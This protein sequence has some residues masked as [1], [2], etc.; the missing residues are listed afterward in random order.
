MI[1]LILLPVLVP[2][3][4]FILLL[5]FRR[6]VVFNQTVAIVS[7]LIQL[8]ISLLLLNR[9]LV[10][11]IQVTQLGSWP[12]PYGITIV[13]DLFSAIMVALSGIIATVIGI[14][15]VSGLSKDYHKGSFYPLMAVL[16]MGVNGAFL[17]GDIFNLYVWFEVMILASFVLLTMG[18]TRKQ[19]YGGMKYMTI[20][21]VSSMIFL[22]GIGVLYG[23]AGSLNMADIAVK[24][25]DAESTSMIS[26]SAMLF[27]IAFGIKA[28]LFPF[29]FWLPASYYTPPVVIT[30]FFSGL[31]TKVGIYSMIRVFTLIFVHER[32]LWQPIILTVGGLTMVIGVLTAASQ[33]DIRK[34][35][36]F[37]I[38]SQI[39]YMVMGLGLFTVAGLAG[40]VYFLAHNII[41]KTN[42][43]LV[44]GIVNHIKGSFDLKVLGGLYKSYPFIAILMFIPTMGLAG[45]PPLSGFFGKLLLIIAGI[46]AKHWV[47]TGV[48]VWVSLI[49]LFSMIKI[50][51]EGFWKK[52]PEKDSGVRVSVPFTMLL[53]AIVLA[54]LTVLLGVFAEP[55][56]EISTRAGEQLINP[57]EYIQAV[58]RRF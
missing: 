14:Y 54:L 2:F 32:E 16:L 22:A 6:S 31:M 26:V 15:S 33:Y 50:W 36:S 5:F 51:N 37:H 11:G 18:G 7:A 4:T 57:S 41:T 48:A 17:T 40:A 20:N 47:I 56:I 21:L 29:F 42:T 53:P 52:Q 3:A 38:I 46:E 28:A 13:A 34:I 9:V 43:F 1:P 8:I 58:L 49:T 39:G 30:A 45:I 24:L 10:E 19:M 35:L 25:R 55:F 44:A 23:Q 27:F 12:A